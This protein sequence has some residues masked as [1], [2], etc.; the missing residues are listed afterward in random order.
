MSFFVSLHTITSQI[1]GHTH[2]PH[3]SLSLPCPSHKSPIG[4]R[5]RE[6]GTNERRGRRRG[7]KVPA[8]SPTVK[9]FVFGVCVDTLSR[10]LSACS[11]CLPSYSSIRVCVCVCACVYA[12][13]SSFA[14]G[15]VS[16]ETDSDGATPLRGVR[17]LFPPNEVMTSCLRF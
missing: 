1:H 5:H 13:V 14:G 9:Y 12:T 2:Q 16:L 6:R 4:P 10:S 11:N 8:I 15:N 17:M 7:V 3:H